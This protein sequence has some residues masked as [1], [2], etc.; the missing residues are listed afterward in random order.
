[1]RRMHPSRKRSMIDIWLWIWVILIKS[2]FVHQLFVLFSHPLTGY[3]FVI[4]VSTISTGGFRH[5]DT[6]PTYNGEIELYSL[7]KRR[8]NY[9]KFGVENRIWCDDNMYGYFSTFN[10]EAVTTINCT[11]KF[12]RA[13]TICLNNN[14]KHNVWITML[15]LLPFVW[16]TMVYI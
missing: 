6:T 11:E 15:E 10:T 3:D 9:R 5:C 7:V 2:T 14:G 12:K 8:N 4:Y 16:I 13:F 1:M